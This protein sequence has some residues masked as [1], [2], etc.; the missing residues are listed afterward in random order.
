MIW[1]NHGFTIHSFIITLNQFSLFA[2]PSFLE[3]AVSLVSH[4]LITFFLFSACPDRTTCRPV[5]FAIVSLKERVAPFLFL[6]NTGRSSFILIALSLQLVCNLSC[7]HGLASE[8]IDGP[9]TSL[10]YHL[11]ARS[12][13][14]TFAQKEHDDG[15][16]DPGE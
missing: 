7:S 5:L 14:S 6:V 3:S 12:C 1:N 13:R 10:S 4:P 15:T 11:S 16:S 9:Y 8:I 2:P